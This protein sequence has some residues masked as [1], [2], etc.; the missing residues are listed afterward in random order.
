ME[1]FKDIFYV[2]SKKLGLGCNQPGKLEPFCKKS[3]TIFSKLYKLVV[4]IW[5]LIIGCFH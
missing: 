3:G 5:L 1:S 2:V 4:N